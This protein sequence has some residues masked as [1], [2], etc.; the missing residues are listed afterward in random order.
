[1]AV[2]VQ[3]LWNEFLEKGL[4]IAQHVLVDIFLDQE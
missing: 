4:E 1:V 3:F 2:E